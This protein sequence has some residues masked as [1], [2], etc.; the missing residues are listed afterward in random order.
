MPVPVETFA[1]NSGADPNSCPKKSEH[2]YWI[3][4]EST[5]TGFGPRHCILICAHVFTVEILCMSFGLHAM[6]IFVRN[7]KMNSEW[8]AAKYTARS[9][10]S[11]SGENLCVDPNA[12]PNNNRSVPQNL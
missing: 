12:N 10:E 9:T 1:V 8:F 4:S 11:E 7:K 6:G 2:F 3:E 5:K